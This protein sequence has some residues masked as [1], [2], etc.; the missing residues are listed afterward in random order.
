M[1]LEHPDVFGVHGPAV[2]VTATEPAPRVADVL[3]RRPRGLVYVFT[4]ASIGDG[5][6]AIEASLAGAPV[7]LSPEASWPDGV[8]ERLADHFLHAEGLEVPVEPFA[9]VTRAIARG[10]GPDLWHAWHEM[11][12]R[13]FFVD[14]ESRVSLSA[15]WAAQGRF[16]GTLDDDP[17]DYETSDLWREVASWR[18]RVFTEMG[19][20]STCEHFPACGGFWLA[21]GSDASVCAG[22][23][24]ALALLVAAWRAHRDE[25]GVDSTGDTR[26]T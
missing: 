7:R 15:R 5:A 20:C 24:R 6:P 22:W 23:Q 2:T 19:V 10:K 14:R 9:T 21:D 8:L 26:A 12:G 17:D 16:F 25:L 3:A 18:E 13:D 4:P 11:P 1:F